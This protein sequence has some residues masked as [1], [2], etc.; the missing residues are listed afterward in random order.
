MLECDLLDSLSKSG[1]SCT[2]CYACYNVCPGNAIEMR[3]DELGFRYPHIQESQCIDCGL[4]QKSCPVLSGFR[5]KNSVTPDCY[6]LQASAEVRSVSSSGG[7]FTLLAQT[8]LDHDGVVFGAAMLQDLTVCHTCAHTTEQLA[9]LRKSKYVQSDIGYTYREV[10]R[11]LEQKQPVLFSG[12]PCQVAGLYAYLGH[13]WDNLYTVDILCHGVPSHQM[14]RDSLEEITQSHNVTSVDFRDKLF[15]WE[16]LGM[17]LTFDNGARRRLSYDE[18]RY[19]QGFHPNITLRESCF[20]CPFSQYP[21]TG[22]V[23]IGDFWRVADFDPTFADGHGTSALL[24]NSTKGQYLLDKAR[25]H[26][27]LLEPVPL[28]FLD[29]NRVTPSITKPSERETFLELYPKRSFNKSVLFAQQNRHDVGIV[30]NWSYPNYGTELTYY[31][32]YRTITDLGYTTVMLSWPKDS[33]WKPYAHA[34]LFA[35]DP[36][37][38]RDIAEIPSFRSELTNYNARCDTFVLGSDQLL[39]DNLYER[40]G[41]FVQLDWVYSNKKKIAYATSFG[42]DYIWGPDENRAELAHFLQEFDFVSAREDSGCDLLQNRFGVAAKQ[43]LDPVFLPSTTIYQKLAEIGQSSVPSTPY[44]FTY[45]LDKAT[46]HSSLLQQCAQQLGLS[47]FSVTDAAPQE[48]RLPGESNCAT[49]LEEW[50]ACIQNCTYM[51]T[52][53]F[54]GMCMAILMH[55]PFIAL[56]NDSR[57][58]A[59]FKSILT[60][61]NLQNRLLD[62]GE[63]LDSRLDILH[64]PIDYSTVEQLLTVLRQQ[65]TDW[66]E[67]ALSAQLVSKSLSTYD[68][69]NRRIQ[70]LDNQT[71]QSD[72][73][74]WQQLEDHRSRLDGI[75][76]Q[77]NNFDTCLN[78]LDDKLKES[79]SEL[80]AA[81]AR[82]NTLERQLDE[83]KHK[84]RY[85]VNRILKK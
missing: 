21:R 7:A 50:L 71:T 74:Q 51:I 58:A 47:L 26:A 13:N 61:L 40:F 65:S 15:G 44:L 52:D 10:K 31:A 77:I 28:S 32:L 80:Q 36:Y 55:R 37:P 81:I 56:C 6:A 3:T 17:T 1:L 66:L 83:R 38:P 39:N 75:D 63:Q 11:F 49:T 73:K 78:K 60:L 9:A 42:T 34:Q 14:L 29:T 45:V 85:I 54:H 8:V 27:A 68:L 79:N 57:G 70:Y 18:S 41:H 19:E 64:H 33:A 24:I 72:S 48:H 84:I 76:A 59:R 22:D 62:S 5:S 12:T 20:I 67:N 25:P 16:S 43:V 2:G 35:K 82:L 46:V 23:T 53:S 4:C 30:G 69:L